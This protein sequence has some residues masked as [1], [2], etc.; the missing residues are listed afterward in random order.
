MSTASWVVIYFF[1]FQ[2]NICIPVRM[3]C[4]CN[5]NLDRFCYICSNVVLPKHQA[6]I[7][8]FV[9]KAY[10]DY[11]GI[12]L[13]DQD[14]PFT[15][16]VCCN[17]CVE[18]L[19]DWRN[20]KRKSMPFAIP[21][22]WR[23]GKDHIIDYY[24][25]MINLKGINCKNEHHVQYPDVHSVIR[26]ILH[27]PYLPVPESDVNMEYSSDSEHSDTTVVARDEAYKL[28]EDDQPIPLTQAELSNLTQDLNLSKES[29]AAARLTSQRKTSVDTRNNIPLALRP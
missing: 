13:G 23:E 1:S 9:K 25:C 12:I 29:C 2:F 24:C 6:K 21:M 16:Q 28:E 15:P 22:V 18:N 27:G 14:K 19:R 10:R 5:N 26:P 3:N 17:I 7:T 4:K 8:D 20:G 11:F